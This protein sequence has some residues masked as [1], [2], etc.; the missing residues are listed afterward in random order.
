MSDK[1]GL[2]YDPDLN[3]TSTTWIHED[4]WLKDTRE[5]LIIGLVCGLIFGALACYGVMR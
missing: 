3:V 2:H 1:S 4:A 5:T